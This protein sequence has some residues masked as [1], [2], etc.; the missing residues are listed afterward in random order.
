[1]DSI[2]ITDS[3]FSLDTPYNKIIDSDSSSLTTDYTTFFYIG[4]SVLAAFI[5]MFI[6]KFYKNK[7]SAQ[8][9]DSEQD[10]PGGFCTIDQNQRN[11]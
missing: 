10:C 6:Y 2:D 3:A 1:M 11:I 9:I 5:G 8:I 4:V 7:Q